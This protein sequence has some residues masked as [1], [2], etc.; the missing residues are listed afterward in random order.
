MML[1]SSRQSV[2]FFHK[3]G[4]EKMMNQ[5]FLVL[6]GAC[7]NGWCYTANESERYHVCVIIG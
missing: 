4:L 3:L 5:L 2:R 7:D 1:F 6:N